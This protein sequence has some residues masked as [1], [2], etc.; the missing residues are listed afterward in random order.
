MRCLSSARV[1]WHR[2]GSIL[3]HQGAGAFLRHALGRMLRPLLTWQTILFFEI[4]PARDRPALRAAIPLDVRVLEAE[5]VRALRPVFE[6][7]GLA[8]DKVER[9]LARGDR[10][11]VGLSEGQVVHFRWH[12]T[13]AAWIPELGATIVPRPG[14]TYSHNA[15]TLESARG[16]NVQPAIS[17]FVHEWTR[18]AGYHRTIFYVLEDNYPG[19]AIVRKMAARRTR[20]LRRFR[21]PALSGSWITGLG[22]PGGPTIR[23]EA[24]VSVRRMGPLGLWVHEKRMG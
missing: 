23:F 14:E 15:F 10:C 24:D 9:W 13:V 7:A 16:K 22:G 19:L 5:E 17:H 4:D 21:F 8:A 6:E 11:A 20:V 12:T 2:E 1:T 18:D 3:R